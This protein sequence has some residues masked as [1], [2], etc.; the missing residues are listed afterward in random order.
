[1]SKKIQASPKGYSLRVLK[2]Y[3]IY[4]PFGILTGSKKNCPTIPRS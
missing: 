3:Y 4:I 2:I 1:M